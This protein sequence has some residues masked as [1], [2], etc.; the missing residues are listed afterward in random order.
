MNS[1][2][3]KTSK[4]KNQNVKLINS[5]FCQSEAQDS[6]FNFY[7]S[8]HY[9][10]YLNLTTDHKNREQFVEYDYLRSIFVKEIY[11]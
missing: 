10:S 3:I 9:K 2:Q 4:K 7:S 5:E 6:S 8:S 11:I 1:N